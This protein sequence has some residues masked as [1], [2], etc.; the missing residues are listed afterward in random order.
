[1]KDKREIVSVKTIVIAA[2]VP[3]KR[4]LDAW[5]VCSPRSY[6]DTMARL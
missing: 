3:K 1:M 6:V 2:R 5:G 4:I